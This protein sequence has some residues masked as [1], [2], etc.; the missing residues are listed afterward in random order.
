MRVLIRHHPLLRPVYVKWMLLVLA[1][2]SLWLGIVA[3]KLHRELFSMPWVPM[4]TLWLV[5]A[6]FLALGPHNQRAREFALTLPLPARSV[7]RAHVSALLLTTGGMMALTLA[8]VT[9][10]VLGL[11]SLI[12]PVERPD[13]DLTIPLLTLVSHGLAWWL[14]LAALVVIHRPAV[15]ELPRDR[16][17]YG[18]HLGLVAAAY[19][20]MVGLGFLGP[21]TA[22]VPFAV[23]IVLLVLT[24]RRLPATM[25]IAPRE[26]AAAATSGARMPLSAMAPWWRRRPV[27]M[28]VIQ[29]TSKHPALLLVAAIMLILLGVTFSGWTVFSDSGEHLGVFM[30]PMIAYCL[31]AL[32]GTPLL[33]L[34]VFDHLPLSRSRLLA[35]LIGPQLVFLAVGFLGGEIA[36]IREIPAVE[37]VTWSNEDDI[38]GLRMAPRYFAVSWGDPPVNVGPDGMQSTPP[39]AWR[40]LGPLGPVLYKPFHVPADA[41]LEFAAWQL[42]RAVEH[43]Y[44]A[45]LP[46]DELRD[47]FL[48]EQSDGPIVWRND[49]PTLREAYPDLRPQRFRGLLPLQVLLVGLLFQAAILVYL[50]RFRPGVT[51]RSR[52]VA[53][54]ALLVILMGFYLA[55]FFFSLAKAGDPAG[56]NFLILA[57]SN[58]LVTV[59]PGGPV[60]MWIV[61]IAVLAVGDHLVRQRF[62][63]AEWPPVREDDGFCEV[64]G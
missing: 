27:W 53:F 36:L 26:P 12:D 25:S 18:R 45:S 32:T 23:A 64:L 29:A 59:V 5:P 31:F 63:R 3:M 40:P 8:F 15:A 37:M 54:V 28:T 39:N 4:T 20:G 9:Y 48:A 38:Y 47:R 41:S 56:L 11:R 24:G 55:P 50:G 1:T 49:A 22:L 58:L 57:V 16:A 44:G 6:L 43:V 10:G 19:V 7:W 60:A 13:V 17:W 30:I 52:K 51:D 62:R 42:A 61:A 34:A 14:L 35:C 2:G 21:I 46:M 33:K